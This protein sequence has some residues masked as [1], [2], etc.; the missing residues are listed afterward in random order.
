MKGHPP[1]PI[2]AARDR[3]IV[4]RRAAGATLRELSEAYGITKSRVDQIAGNHG[5]PHRRQAEREKVIRLSLE[6][7][8][9]QEIASEFGITRGAAMRR[10]ANVGATPNK[11]E[12]KPRAPRVRKSYYVRKHPVLPAWDRLAK[13]ILVQPGGCWKWTGNLNKYG[14]GETTFHL[15]GRTRLAHRLV[16]EELVGEIPRPLV[17]DHLCRTTWCVH[18]GH[19]DIT[20]IGENSRRGVHPPGQGRKR[21]VPLCPTS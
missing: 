20:D 5:V 7:K 4:E 10:I 17:I 3:E 18:P 21:K 9:V 15:K 11:P 6:G 19:M 2:I 8:T 1:S 13:Y 12:P 16:Y 14:Y